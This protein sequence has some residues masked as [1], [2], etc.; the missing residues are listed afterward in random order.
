[1][2]RTKE[3]SIRPRSVPNAPLTYHA[4]SLVT[5]STYEGVHSGVSSK[6]YGAQKSCECASLSNFRVIF[7]RLV[8]S[9][10]GVHHEGVTVCGGA[11]KGEVD[12]AL[13]LGQAVQKGAAVELLD[14]GGVGADDPA[15]EMKRMGMR[16]TMGKDTSSMHTPTLPVRT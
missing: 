9:R 10:W 16:E 8:S 5:T 2:I 12:A 11:V 14:D 3:R 4:V 15:E 13:L 1:M 6:Q 7:F